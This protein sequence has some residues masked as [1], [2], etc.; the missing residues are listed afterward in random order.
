MTTLWAQLWALLLP[1][2]S[3]DD[4]GLERIIIIPPLKIELIPCAIFDRDMGSYSQLSN[5]ELK[6]EPSGV[7]SAK[8]RNNARN[9]ST[10]RVLTHT[11]QK[12]YNFSLIL[13][14]F[15]PR[16]G[17]KFME[18]STLFSFFLYKYSL[19]TNPILLMLRCNLCRS[20]RR[21]KVTFEVSQL[22]Y[23]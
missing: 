1:H 13:L 2:W 12:K 3:Y 8:T 18:N 17:G 16:V 19:F 20:R 5:L 23:C 6:C 21:K 7:Q 9:L 11:K 15:D 10:C 14:Y 22:F 4:S